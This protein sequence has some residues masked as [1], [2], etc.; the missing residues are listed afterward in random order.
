MLHQ[1]D[2]DILFPARA[3]RSLRNLR[4]PEWRALVDRV[5]QHTS[6]QHPD[7]LAFILMMV[8]QNSCLSCHPHTFRAMRGC[9]IC[10]QQVIARYKG[11]DQELI[12]LW[13]ATRQEILQLQLSPIA[14]QS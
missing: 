11:D 7:V 14:E 2:T 3:I 6:E 5:S 8:R 10:A 9:T 4:G 13:E 1:P 12:Q